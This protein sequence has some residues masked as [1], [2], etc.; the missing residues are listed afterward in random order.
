MRVCQLVLHTVATVKYLSDYTQISS[1]PRS[2]KAREAMKQTQ[3]ARIKARAI[4]CFVEL[5]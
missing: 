5:A 3:A 4:K 1:P 2:H